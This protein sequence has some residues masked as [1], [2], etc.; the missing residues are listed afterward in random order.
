L[1][2]SLLWLD[3]DRSK[4]GRANQRRAIRGCCGSWAVKAD[5]FR[6]YGAA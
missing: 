3:L 2:F 5:A 4:S 6:G 1:D